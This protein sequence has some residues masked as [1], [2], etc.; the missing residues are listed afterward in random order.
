MKKLQMDAMANLP[1]RLAKID[2]RIPHVTSSHRSWMK[3]QKNPTTMDEV[4]NVDSSD[5]ED[6]S[7]DVSLFSDED[8]ARLLC[9]EAQDPNEA[10]AE[11]DAI[12]YPIASFLCPISCALFKDPVVC[13]DGVTYERQ[14]I[15]QWLQ[16][17]NTSPITR[18]E[19]SDTTQYRNIALKSAMDEFKEFTRDKKDTHNKLLL[20]MTRTKKMLNAAMKKLNK[21]ESENVVLKDTQNK[22]EIEKAALAEELRREEAGYMNGFNKIFREN[23]VMKSKLEKAKKELKEEQAKRMSIVEKM[24]DIVKNEMALTNPKSNKKAKR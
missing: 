13:Q 14:Y 2:D 17:S 19:I 6:D 1:K 8:F 18:E 12:I 21:L 7:D 9:E 22:L 20:A 15:D 3:S 10:E 24:S 11:A 23:E 5:A 16:N 4:I